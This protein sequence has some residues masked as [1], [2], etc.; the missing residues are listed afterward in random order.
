[1]LS[2]NKLTHFC[3]AHERVGDNCIDN[4]IQIKEYVLGEDAREIQHF[5][6]YHNI[7]ALFKGQL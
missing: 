4:I 2:C 3:S 6:F 5:Y 1:M 7:P